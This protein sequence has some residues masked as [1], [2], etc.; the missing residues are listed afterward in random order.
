MVILDSNGGIIDANGAIT[1]WLA[2]TRSTLLGKSFRDILKT[3]SKDAEHALSQ[4][5]LSS[6]V[7]ATTRLKLNSGIDQPAQW[8]SLEI[9]Q[10]EACNFI[11]VNSILPPLAD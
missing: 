1:N 4:P 6:Q 3:L 5:A 9:A 8:L 7:F 11:R 10:A 2:T